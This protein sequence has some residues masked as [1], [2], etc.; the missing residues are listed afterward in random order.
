MFI[1]GPAGLLEAEMDAAV[2]AAEQPQ[3]IAVLCHPH[4]QYGGSMQ[5]NVVSLLSRSFVSNGISGL[6]FNFRGVG[7]SAGH[8]GDGVGEVEDILAVLSWCSINYPAAKL[9]L[10]GY[11]F[12]AM[13]V[14]KSLPRIA[15]LEVRALQA[16]I[17]V[18]PPV[19]MMSEQVKITCPLLVLVGAED[20]IVDSEAVLATLSSSAS[21]AAQSEQQ[22]K[23]LVDV[24][25]LPGADH[26]FAGQDAV[27]LGHMADFIQNVENT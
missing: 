18:A 12:G 25:I 6:R 13:M 23:A 5:D 16:V 9:Y 19:Q 3:A 24:K 10:C 15:E 17:L 22:E 1:E 20:K 27:L 7:G 26:F 4:P 21:S 11:S 8:Y 14:L 2:I